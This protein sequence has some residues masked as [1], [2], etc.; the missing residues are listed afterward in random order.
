MK[1]LMVLLSAVAAALAW[2][3]THKRRSAAG[4]A[5]LSM[6]KRVITSLLVGIGVYFGLMLL[7]MLYLISPVA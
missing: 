5:P 6:T 1:I 3:L 4:L 2:W 7:A